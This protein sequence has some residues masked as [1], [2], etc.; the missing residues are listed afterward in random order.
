[1]KEGDLQD[2]GGEYSIYRCVF[3]AAAAAA[4]ALG[5]SRAETME[6]VLMSPCASC[7]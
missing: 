2:K 7:S 6:Q 4:A 3:N 1:M 5:E